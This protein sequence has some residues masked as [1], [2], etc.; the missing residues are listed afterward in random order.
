MFS[1]FRFNDRGFNKMLNDLQKD[2]YSSFLSFGSGFGNSLDFPKKADPN[3]I[4]SEEKIETK[5]SVTLKET[6][7]SKDG[8]STFS[9]T[10]I[11]PKEKEESQEEIAEKIK[12]A[13]VAE[14]YELAAKLKKQL[15]K[16]KKGD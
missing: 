3:F 5:D 9:K 12:S 16:I 13:V 14:D 15:N 6:W 4:F 2:A 1:L 11:Q 8:I 10:T 7:K